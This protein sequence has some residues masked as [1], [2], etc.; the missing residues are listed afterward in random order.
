MTSGPITQTS[1]VLLSAQLTSIAQLT[2]KSKNL[3]A[4]SVPGFQ[5]LLV[6]PEENVQVS[7]DSQSISYV[8]NKGLRRD[9]T[10]G[11]PHTTEH[12]FDLTILGHGYFRVE[13]G[14]YT[15]NGRFQLDPSGRLMTPTGKLVLSAGGGPITI[16]AN[17]KQ[18]FISE[19]G[20]ISTEK[21]PTGDSVGVF[22]VAD[23]QEMSYAGD[24]LYTTEQQA[25][26]LPFP[27]LVQGAYE[28]SN[29]QSVKE[30]TDLITIENNMKAIQNLINDTF[31]QSQ[32]LIDIAPSA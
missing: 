24:G 1:T 22:N 13:G 11:S 17:A 27:R 30:V 15:R 16:P 23:E 8:Q 29:V 7:K 14:Q 19:T 4:S 2:A 20:V 18:I 28:E 9:T 10:P 32:A 5:A 31:E 21:G 25:E 26:L 12:P 3:A 6:M